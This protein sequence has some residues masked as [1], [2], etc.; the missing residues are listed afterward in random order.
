[1]EYMALATLVEGKDYFIGADGKAHFKDMTYGP[2]P[3]APAV[4]KQ[5]KAITPLIPNTIRYVSQITVSTEYNAAYWGDYSSG[6][7][8]AVSCVS[9][10]LSSLGVDV[11]PKQ[12]CDNNLKSG[13][14]P[15]YMYWGNSGNCTTYSGISSLDECLKKYVDDPSKYA[16]P[17]IRFPNRQHYVVVIGKN[18]D[19]TYSIL[20]PENVNSTVWEGSSTTQ[21]IQY[22]K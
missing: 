19:G 11:L 14:D 10:A 12:V 16:P 17:I 22:S 5:G 15:V 13:T 2:L 18:D 4:D 1:M 20:N 3:P 21:I 9:M 6:A 7:G 8:C